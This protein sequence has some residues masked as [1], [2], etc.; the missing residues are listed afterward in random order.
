MQLDGRS[1]NL[2]PD[3][4]LAVNGEARFKLL[5]E[6]PRPSIEEIFE[7]FPYLCQMRFQGPL[8][9]SKRKKK[10][11]KGTV[12]AI[13]ATNRAKIELRRSHK[14]I[15]WQWTKKERLKIEKNK[16]SLL[17]EKENSGVK[18][19]KM[20]DRLISQREKIEEILA[21][22]KKYSVGRTNE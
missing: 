11:K 1:W 14:G 20:R 4:L 7:R 15:G 3:N 10:L 12:N 2:H 19:Q 9:K 13:K 18:K 8:P 5:N 21:V 16:K 22:D 17:V 6:N